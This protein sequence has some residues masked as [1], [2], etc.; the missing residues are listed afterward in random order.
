MN[1]QK[2]LPVIVRKEVDDKHY[3]FVNEQYYPSVTAILDEA[4]PVGFGLRNWLLNNTAESAEEIKNTTAD[5]GTKMHDAFQSLLLGNKLNLA[6]EFKLM[7]EKKH[8]AT[9]CQWFADFAPD[10]STI[11]TEHTVA[12]VTH[13]YA[14]TLDLAIRKDGELWIVDFKTGS[15]IYFS[16]ELQLTA[17]KFAYEEMYGVKVDHVAVLRTGSR[18]KSGY[19]FKEIV[20]DFSEFERVYGTYLALHDGKIPDPPVMDA[21]PLEVQL[22]VPAIKPKGVTK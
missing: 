20:R 12:S 11:Q 16:H 15:G 18:H 2:I 22:F 4:A 21:Y 3:Y 8:I 6:D 17:Y 19:E 7:K 9:F 13:K 14:G 10:I 1:D 5:L